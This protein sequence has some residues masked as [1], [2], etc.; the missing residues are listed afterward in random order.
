MFCSDKTCGPVHR[1]ECFLRAAE[2]VERLTC[3]DCHPAFYP[4]RHEMA[5]ALREMAAWPEHPD[6][7]AVLRAL[8]FLAVYPQVPRGEPFPDGGETA[9]EAALSHG[10]S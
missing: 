8:R 4:Q 1:A 7:Q 5:R 2:Q 9:D 6:H 10:R 3:E